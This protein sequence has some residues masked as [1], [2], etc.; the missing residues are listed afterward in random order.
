VAT[1]T[2]ANKVYDGTTSASLTFGA[3]SG[4][5]SGD[6]VSIDGLSGTFDTK[7]VGTGKTVTVS[8]GSLSGADAGNYQI[9]SVAGSTTANITKKDLGVATVTAANKVYDGNTSASLTFGAS[10]GVISGDDVSIDGLS[11][12]FDTKNVGTGKTVTV[13]GGSLSGVDAGNYQI[14]SVAGSTTANI[15]KKDLGVATVTAANKVYDGNTSAS[16]TFG[17]S[18]GV[19]SGDDVSIDGL[20]GTFDTKNVG[21]GKTVTV[22]GGSLSGTDAGNYQISSVAGTTTANIDKASLTISTSNVAKTYDGTTTAVGSAIAVAGTAVMTGDSLAGGSFAFVDKNAGTNKTVTASAVTVNDGNGGNNYT[23][24]YANNTTSLINK[25]D[26]T[27]TANSGT[28]PY[29]GQIQSVSGFTATGLVSGETPAVL[30]NVTAGGSGKDIGV[31][32]TTASGSDNNYNLAFVAGT[33]NITEPAQDEAL[34]SGVSSVSGAIQQQYYS[35]IA[36]QTVMPQGS[37]IVQI[38]GS[39]IRLP[40]DMQ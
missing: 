4:V 7:N 9:S 8:G 20:S 12:T 40:P 32:A 3:S 21:T 25:K 37:A 28:T 10:S 2:A 39:G 36:P 35:G 23:V 26:A 14:S 30:T 24:S 31:Y 34:G 15:T 16:L 33:L 18:S 5:I 13:S 19:I 38:E 6:D 1:V 22:S 27:V 11:G 17:A 29:S